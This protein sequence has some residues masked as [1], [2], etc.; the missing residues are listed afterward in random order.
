[1]GLFYIRVNVK[2]LVTGSMIKLPVLVAELGSGFVV[3]RNKT[4]VSVSVRTMIMHAHS[5]ADFVST[6]V[7]F[8]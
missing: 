8:K 7:A 3:R 2:A 4:S 5:Y 1:M 6:T